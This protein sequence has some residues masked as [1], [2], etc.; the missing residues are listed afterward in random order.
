MAFLI[1]VVT[2]TKERKESSDYL[3]I[4]VVAVPVR[5]PQERVVAVG[6]CVRSDPGGDV[7]TLLVLPSA[8]SSRHDASYLPRRSQVVLDPLVR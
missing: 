5:E 3:G 8:V 2:D 6:Q 4:Q 1:G 7:V